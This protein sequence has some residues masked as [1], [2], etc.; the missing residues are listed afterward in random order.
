MADIAK[1]D[2]RGLFRESYRIE[3]IVIEE[4]RSIF[5]DWALF[6]NLDTA[7][8]EIQA[9]LDH[10]GPDNPDHPMTQVLKEGVSEKAGQSDGRSRTGR[11]RAG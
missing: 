8:D 10:Y 11:R 5:M 2:P 7:K 1:I 9:L 6:S 3:G 4:C